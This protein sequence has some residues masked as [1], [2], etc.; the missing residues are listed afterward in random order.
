VLAG[1][2]ILGPLS[3]EIAA[4]TAGFNPAMNQPGNWLWLILLALLPPVTLW[5]AT[6]N[7]M[8]FSVVLVT[9]VLIFLAQ[10]GKQHGSTQVD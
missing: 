5:F 6:L 4:I 9:L 8:I 2:Y 3:M 10:L 1:I 7:G